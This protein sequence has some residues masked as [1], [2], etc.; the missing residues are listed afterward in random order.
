MQRKMV[1][2][3]MHSGRL[4]RK[5][6]AQPHCAEATEDASTYDAPNCCR[7]HL[8]AAATYCLSKFAIILNR[9]PLSSQD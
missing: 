1:H 9:R 6:L 8:V 7:K 3:A 4:A 2:S 5:G